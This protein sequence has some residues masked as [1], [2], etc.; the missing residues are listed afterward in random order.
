MKAIQIERVGGPEVMRLA[1]VAIGEPAPGQVRVRHTACGVN[2]ID[3]YHRTGLYPLALPAVLGVEGAGVVEAVGA[4]VTH[5]SVGDRVA[6]AARSPGSYAQARVLDA[7][8]V[9]RLPDGIDDA[10][11]AADTA[12]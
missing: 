3:T 2:F 12:P 1:D 8:P 9:V 10:R 4:D 7:T 5:I 11:G 6:Y